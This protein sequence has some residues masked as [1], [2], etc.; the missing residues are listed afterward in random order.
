MGDEEAP[1]CKVEYLDLPDGGSEET[2]WIKR[3]GRCRVT[4]PNGDIFEGTYDAE[5]V[6]QGRGTYI[7]M[8]P[9]SEEDETLIEKAKYE[10]E[11]KNGL[12]HGV[13]KMKFP[14]GDI[15]EGEWFEDKVNWIFGTFLNTNYLLYLLLFFSISN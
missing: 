6:K 3:G 5:K 4:Y 15:Y 9:T 12:K 2:N 10:G 13:G 7:W 11:Y 1:Q 8:G 14:N